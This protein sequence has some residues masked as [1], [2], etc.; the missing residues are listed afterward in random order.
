MTISVTLH[1]LHNSG[2]IVPLYK[3]S[4]F[5]NYLVGLKKNKKSIKSMRFIY[6]LSRDVV[7]IENACSARD[8]KLI[9][10]FAPWVSKESYKQ[11]TCE[12]CDR[13]VK[14]GVELK[15]LLRP[16]NLNA[17]INLPALNRRALCPLC[18]PKEEGKL[19]VT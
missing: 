7:V 14:R 17:C 18:S 5:L 15:F 16:H 3:F 13:E 1:S 4:S 10:C 6:F 11:K 19:S 12:T 9:A 8:A 2:L